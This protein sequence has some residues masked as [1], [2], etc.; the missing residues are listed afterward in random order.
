MKL[1]LIEPLREYVT[2][3]I[4]RVHEYDLIL[5]VLDYSKTKFEVRLVQ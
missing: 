2:F 1:K 5:N 4:P 3:S